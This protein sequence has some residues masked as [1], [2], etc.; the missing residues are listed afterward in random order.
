MVMVKAMKR[1]DMLKSFAANGV[2]FKRQGKGDHDVWE[3]SC[4]QDHQAVLTDTH[5]I[6]P[7]LVRQAIQNLSCLPKGWLQ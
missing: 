7:G 5:E 4:G 2:L 1:R 6:S 3:C